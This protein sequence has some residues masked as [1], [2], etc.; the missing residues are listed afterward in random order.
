MYSVSEPNNFVDLTDLDIESEWN[1][2]YDDSPL[3][4]PVESP[5]ISAESG[6]DLMYEC[7]FCLTLHLPLLPCSDNYTFALPE[8][9]LYSY[10]PV[11]YEEPVL[12]QSN[13]AIQS[14]YRKWL[15]SLAR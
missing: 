15:V 10:Q 4:Q 6:S 1:P 13:G 8:S 3:I 7:A 12:S 2:Q 9:A 14:N 5:H 11:A